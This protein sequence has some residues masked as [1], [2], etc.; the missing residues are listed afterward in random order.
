MNATIS[1][2]ADFVENGNVLI[3][4]F[5]VVPSAEL[6]TSIVK[7]VLPETAVKFNAVTFPLFTA[8]V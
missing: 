7:P 4:V 6:F 2:F 1:S 3:V 5:A 8:V